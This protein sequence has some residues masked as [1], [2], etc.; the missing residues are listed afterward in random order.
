[1]KKGEEKEVFMADMRDQYVRFDWA[2]K[3]LLRQKA[4]FS[5]LE[6]FLT[7]LLG[8]KVTIVEILESEGNQQYAEDKYNR[9]DIKAKNS[10]G[11]IIIVEVQ[12]TRE[13]YFLERILYG[14]SKAV[15]EH[16]DLGDDYDKVKKVYSVSILYFDLGQ[17]NDY[18]YHGQTHFIGVHTG[19]RLKVSMKEQKAITFRSPS[20]IYPEYFLIRVNEFDKVAVTPLEEWVKYLKTG[21]ISPDTQTPG[22][23]EARERLRYYNMT[24]AERQAYDKHIDAIRFQNDILNTAKW[25]GLMEGR[26]EGRMEGREEGKREKQQEIAR[27]LKA[28]G[29][30]IDIIVKSTGLSAE[31]ITALS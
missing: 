18:L 20:E 1:M 8:E 28:N 27:N 14:V 7:V 23:A 25:E 10:K 17:G 15:T 22:L 29:V 31:E 11:E 5:V 4:N 6:G 30:P 12:N 2:I 13:L 24:T 19:D 26:L 16:I 21:I 9:V 3:R